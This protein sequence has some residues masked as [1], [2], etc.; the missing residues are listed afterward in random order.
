MRIGL[1]TPIIQQVPSRSSPWERDAGPAELVRVAQHADRLGFAWITCSDHIGVPRSHAAAMGESWY[2]PVATLSFLAAH[3]SRVA[4]LSHVLVL[5][6]RHPLLV[7]KSFATLDRLSEGRVILG[8]GS[9]HL[10]AEF[11][12]LGVDY[13][14]RGRQTDEA[15]AALRTALEE[16][17]S[18]FAGDFYAWRDMAIAPRPVQR[19][20]PPLWVGGNGVNALRRAA[21]F[22]DGWIPWEL[23][24]P[25]F[26]ESAKVLRDLSGR[27]DLEIVAPAELAL[28]DQPERLRERLDA[29]AAAG[30]TAFHL[31][32]QSD[33]LEQLLARMEALAPVLIDA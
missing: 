11:R 18:N 13:E 8:I 9:G 22:G 4:L 15:L 26:Q 21:R 16:G 7:A 23:D 29:W 19:P 3:T 25:E 31:R 27:D 2:E 17:T 12:S 10:K 33:S 20:R 30:A 6:Y 1:G 28:S 24:L 32:L 14:A 5:P